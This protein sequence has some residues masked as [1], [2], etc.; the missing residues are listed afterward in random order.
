[1]KTTRGVRALLRTIVG[2]GIGWMARVLLDVLMDR[3]PD[4][5]GHIDLI[6]QFCI[7]LFVAW[8]CLLPVLQDYGVFQRGNGRAD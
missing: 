4:S 1:M 8:F 2:M 6:G 5:A 3:F 7:A